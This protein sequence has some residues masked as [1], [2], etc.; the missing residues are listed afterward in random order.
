MKVT[1]TQIGPYEVYEDKGN[2]DFVNL[3]EHLWTPDNPRNISRYGMA[4]VKVCYITYYFL[5]KGMNDIDGCNT[6]RRLCK[7][8]V[9]G[10]EKSMDAS[11]YTPF[12]AAEKYMGIENDENYTP[13]ISF[14]EVVRE[15]DTQR[16]DEF[17]SLLLELCKIP[18]GEL[19][20]L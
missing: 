20:N 19:E 8:L 10:L 16:W 5:M 1:T 15:F 14:E 3:M 18:M 13:S 17:R 12:I 4:W 7:T 2:E 9:Y 6:A 11:L